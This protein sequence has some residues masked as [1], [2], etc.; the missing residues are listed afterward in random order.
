MVMHW[1]YASKY[2]NCSLQ[3]GVSVEIAKKKKNAKALLMKFQ[4]YTKDSFASFNSDLGCN[5]VL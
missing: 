4:I 5:I 2:G 1:V 3:D